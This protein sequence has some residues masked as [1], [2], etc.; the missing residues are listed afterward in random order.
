MKLTELL[1]PFAFLP[2]CLLLYYVL[3]K[4]CRNAAL[5]AASLLFFAWGTPEYLVLLVLAILLNYFAGLELESLLEDGKTGHARLVLVLTI[6]ADLLPLL[7]FKYYGEAAA[8][9]NRVFVLSLPVHALPAPVGVSFYTFTL[10]SALSDVYHGRA[11]ME[12]NLIR[13]ALFVSF[14]PKLTSGPIVQYADMQPQLE[15][16]EFVRERVGSGMRLFVIGLAKKVILAGLLGTPFYALKALGPQALSVCG[17]WLGALLYALMLY[18]DFSGYSD[19]AIGAAKMFGFEFLANFDYPYCA[20]SVAAFW[21][22]WHMSLGFWFRTYI[23]IPLGGQP[24][25]HGQDDLQS[26]ARVAADRHLA[27]RGRDVRRLGPVLWAAADFGEIRAAGRARARA[28]D[29]AQGLDVFAGRDRLGAVFLRHAGA[30][31]GVAGQDVLCGAG[32]ICGRGG[33]VLPAHDLAG[34]A[35]RRVCGAAVR[36]PVRQPV[37]PGRAHGVDGLQPVFYRLAAVV[38]RGHGERDV[39]FVPLCAVLTGGLDTCFIHRK[40]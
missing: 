39:Y 35:D 9:L 31:R 37:F 40:N 19:M 18:F 30:G 8:A 2:V 29:P 20:D 34:A 23:Y 1:Y 14:F 25:R 36:L 15:P 3:P 7:F 24:L 6:L 11:P 33:A 38:H 16:H 10:L 17:A 4:R 12:K 28:V 13:F 22:R 5:L 27:R 21:R 26:A 32:G